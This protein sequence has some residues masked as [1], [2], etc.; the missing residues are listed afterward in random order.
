MRCIPLLTAPL[1]AGSLSLS[2]PARAQQKTA[3]PDTAVARSLRNE[4]RDDPKFAPDRHEGDGPFPRLVIRGAT[5]IDGTGG[6][7]RGPVDIVVEGSRIVD[8]A[9]VGVPHVPI[10]STRRPKAGARE[11]DAKGMYIMPGIVDL[12]VHQGTPQKAPESEYYNKLWLAHG[13][14]TVRGVPFASFAYSV[15]EKERSA[16]NEIAA[17]RY[18]VYQ[19]PGTGWGQGPVTTPEQA[20]AWVRWIKAHGADGLKLGAERPDLMAAL[21]DEAKKLNMGST[22]HLQQTGVAQVNAIKAARLGLGT[23]THF[24]G[25]FESLLKDYVVQPYPV[26]QNY[27]DEYDRFG[28]VAR[29]WD[30]IYPPGT[31]EWKAYLE[32]HLKLGTTFDPTLP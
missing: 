17:P 7:P 12:H 16:K 10:D 27:N 8:I 23:V 15:H 2:V 6:P 32:E 30:K 26:D 3:T 13:I 11:I 14:T 31:P 22:A 29:L 5:L 19:R 21:L 28:Q 4:Q 18:V 24:Y 25:H 20:R 1:L 9:S